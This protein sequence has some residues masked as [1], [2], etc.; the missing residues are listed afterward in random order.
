VVSETLVGVDTVMRVSRFRARSHWE[1]VDQALREAL[2]GFLAQPALVGAWIG[3]RT[4]DGGEERVIVSV[5]SP[6]SAEPEALRIP[7]M[8][9]ARLD[10]EPPERTILP[11]AFHLH[12]PRAA[13][14]TI[15]R[16]YEGRTLP[17]QL[18]RYVEEARQGSDL[19]AKRPDGPHAI[20]MSLDPPDG[21]VTAS[22]WTDWDCIEACTG[23]DVHQ[24]LSTRNRDR[25]AGGRPTHYEIVTVAEH[26]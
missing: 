21:F 1:G 24:P 10:V 13:A 3:R 7:E 17:G 26:G 20:C 9:P 22:L 19:D 6:A 2:P 8:L 25:L 12:V 15:L 14:P 23:G 5:W 18:D 16:I 11:V 4:T